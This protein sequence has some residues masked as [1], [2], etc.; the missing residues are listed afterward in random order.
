M[1]VWLRARRV[2][3]SGSAEA[4]SSLPVVD[5][6]DIEAVVSAWTGIPVERMAEDEKE[7]LLALVRLLGPGRCFAVVRDAGA[8]P[9]V[10][11][12]TEVW[13]RCVLRACVR[14]RLCSRR[15]SSST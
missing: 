4:G 7:R 5:I 9:R 3:L 15:R 12:R 2:E 11:L 8:A 1:A 14:V 13:V 6:G 10:A